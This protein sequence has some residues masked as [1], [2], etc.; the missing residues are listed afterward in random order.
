MEHLKFKIKP[1]FVVF[2]AVAIVFKQGYFATLYSFAVILHETAHYFVAKRLFYRCTEI[3]LG[4][5]GAV[6]YGE[7]DDVAGS[8]RIKIAF[9]GPACNLIL[10]L[11]CVAS[12]WIF[13]EIYYFTEE[14][15]AANFSMAT[16]NLLP[17]YPLD[18][19]R[20]LTGILEKRRKNALTFTKIC[21][22]V[23]SCALFSVF[24]VSLFFHRNL[25][26]V[27]LFAIGLFCGVFTQ[28]GGCYVRSVFL[29][30]K[31]RFL[32]KGMEKKI[33][34]FDENSLLCDVIR[35]MKGN[36]AFCLEVV[37]DD[38]VTKRT[39]D[40]GNLQKVVLSCPPDTVLKELPLQ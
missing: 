31:K 26:S 3:Q 10:C 7:F 11:F 12:W 17:C 34:V 24:V 21:T 29:K 16:I 2:M 27:G 30:N 32:K 15:F 40:F 13:P 18:G 20:I 38:F 39:L 25:F 19:G 37:D 8:D 6:L 9:A 36:Y 33:L 28:S 5:F 23:V 22:Y 14:F 1:S 35:Q 4:I